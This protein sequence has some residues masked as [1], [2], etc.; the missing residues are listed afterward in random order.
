LKIERYEIEL[1]F[2]EPLLGTVAT[3]GWI[4][5][6]REGEI[7]AELL[8]EEDETAPEVEADEIKVTG[9]HSLDDGTPILYDYMIKGFLKEACGT[10]RRTKN[11]EWLSTGVTAH[12]KVIDGLVFPRPRRIVLSTPDNIVPDVILE[13]PLRA[14]T[15]QGERI[16]LAYSHMLPEGTKCIFEVDI[17]GVVTRELLEEWFWYGSYKGMGQWRN[18]SWGRFEYELK[19]LS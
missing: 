6:E 10:L 7:D 2:V 8:I 11:K 14:Q 13:R 9:F 12:K 1:Q 3:D 5:N 18:A 16:A 19:T 17:L 4:R 15:P